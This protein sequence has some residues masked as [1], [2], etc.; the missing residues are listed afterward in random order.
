VRSRAKAP[1]VGSSSE[2]G[3]KRRGVFLAFLAFAVLALGV[4]AASTS[5]A[6]PTVVMG[7]VSD[8]AYATAH[9]SGQVDLHGDFGEYWFEFSTDEESWQEAGRGNTNKSGLQTVEANLKG[10]KG[11]TKYFVRLSAINYVDNTTSSTAPPYSSFTTKPVAAPTA[12]IDP[13]TAFAGTTAHFTGQVNPNAPEAAPT[14]AEVEA[15]FKTT[16]RFECTPECPS[17]SSSSVAADEDPLEVVSDTSGLEPNT[18]YE[19]RLIAENAGGTDTDQTTFHTSTVGP[20]AETFPAFALG[21]GTEALLGGQVNPKNSATKYWFE[22]GPGPGGSSPTYPNSIPTSKDASAGSGALRVFAAQKITGLS[23]ASTYH[24]RLV[25]ENPT[26]VTAGE[27]IDFETPAPSTPPA[28]CPNAKPRAETGSA[29]LPEC[30][31]YEMTTVVDKNGGDASTALGSSP[32]GNRFAYYGFALAF[33]G[34]DSNSAVNS[35]LAQ[36]SS[37]GWSTQSM[38]PPLGTPNLALAGA[39]HNADF[40]SDLSQ[41]YSVARSVSGEP[42]A[43]NITVT[44]ADGTTTWLTAPTVP[45]APYKDKEYAGRSADGSHLVFETTQEMIPGVSSGKQIYDLVNGQV[46]LVSVQ[47]GTSKTPFAESVSVGTGINTSYSAGTG[48]PGTLEQPGAVSEDGSRIFF[49][50]GGSI[51]FGVFVREDGMETRQLDLS[52]RTGHVGEPAFASFVEAAPDGSVA[53]FASYVP[54]TDGADPATGGLYAYDLDADHLRLLAPAFDGL[55]RISQDGSHIYFVSPLQLVPGR[56]VPG[57]HNLYVADADGTSFIANLG[58]FDA[59]VWGGGSTATA[60]V[61]PDGTKL[62]FQSYERLTGFD[63]DGHNEV[64]LY[65]ADDASTTCVSCAPGGGLPTGDASIRANPAPKGGSTGESQIGRP[66]VIS[67]D[68]RKVLFQTSDGLVAGDANGQSDVYLYENGQVRLMSTGTSQYNTEVSDMTPDGNNVFFLTRD[69]LVGQ[70]IDGGARDVYDARVNGG[71]PAPVPA[72]A[73]ESAA[74]CQNAPGT[75][76]GFS[77]PGTASLKGRGNADKRT[78]KKSRKACKQKSR[79][80]HA[81]CVKS[82]KHKKKQHGGKKASKSGRGK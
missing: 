50:I 37:T 80:K 60:R 81:K 6:A 36:R 41:A 22:Y 13:V 69:S 27:D 12:T 29:E 7:S 15:G 46:H 45:G 40:T 38:Q 3:G 47:P 30:R 18:D 61:T 10:L 73:C 54:L 82:K 20:V 39:Y 76:P 75:A 31:A 4:G 16:W 32:D 59:Q 53:V 5:A 55:V 8:V 71:F 63:N 58:Q 43:A 52:E 2:A 66:R 25:A 42:S 78:T 51:A 70:D 14:S 48:F 17:L 19:V 9:V 44:R 74:A 49:G 35:Y 79:K 77:S 1:S 24:F 11:G 64:Y 57:G 21:S 72:E 67:A 68:G 33:A 62:V 26:G 34:A 23:P 65:D 28:D 56:G